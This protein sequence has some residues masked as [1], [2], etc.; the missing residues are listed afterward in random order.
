MI[1]FVT[2]KDRLLRD[3]RKAGINI[4]GFTLIIKPYSQERWGYYDHNKEVIVLFVNKN[5]QEELAPYDDLLRYFLHECT[6]YTQWSDPEFVRYKGIMHNEEFYTLYN[7]FMEET[8][9]IDR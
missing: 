4:T 5:E 3:A 8:N 7:K 1:R 9:K 2:I 6:H